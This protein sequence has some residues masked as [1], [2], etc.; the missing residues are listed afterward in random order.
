MYQSPSFQSELMRCMI[1]E[2]FDVGGADLLGHEDLGKYKRTSPSRRMRGL[3]IA[4]MKTM[5]VID[6]RS[7][8]KIRE[9]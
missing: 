6:R 7:E 1:L 9:A 3:T 2:D 5:D 8:R 4:L